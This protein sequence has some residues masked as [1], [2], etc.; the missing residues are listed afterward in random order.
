MLK[1][2]DGFA[3]EILAGTRILVGTFLAWDGVEKVLWAFGGI[4]EGGPAAI[5]GVA[6]A[7]ELFGGALAA[8][9]SSAL[10]FLSRSRSILRGCATCARRRV[11]RPGW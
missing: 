1:R 7:V 11:G 3:P 8:G 2:L 5:V 6:G 10:L 9:R 4:P